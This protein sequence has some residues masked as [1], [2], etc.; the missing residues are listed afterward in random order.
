M[1]EV[2]HTRVHEA[3]NAR[4]HDPECVNPV[5]PAPT[6]RSGTCRGGVAALVVEVGAAHLPPQK[7][8]R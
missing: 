3:M 1:Q 4:M 2:H 5:A 7:D 8:K 6:G